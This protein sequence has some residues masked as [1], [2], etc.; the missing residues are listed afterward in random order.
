LFRCKS[1]ENMDIATIQPRRR[2]VRSHSDMSVISAS[3]NRRHHRQ[4]R[5]L[6]QPMSASSNLSKSDQ[7][8]LGSTSALF[9]DLLPNF[10]DLPSC[11]SLDGS[12]S[13]T[14]EDQLIRDGFGECENYLP[15]Y[16]DLPSM[17]GNDGDNKRAENP[18]DDPAL[19]RI[20]PDIVG[21]ASYH[22]AAKLKH[23]SFE[24]N[25]FG[26]PFSQ[27]T[28]ETDFRLR[29]FVIAADEYR[30]HRDDAAY[31]EMTDDVV[32]RTQSMD[33]ITYVFVGHG[34]SSLEAVGDN[35]SGMVRFSSEPSSYLCKEAADTGRRFRE[36][37]TLTGS[38]SDNCLLSADTQCPTPTGRSLSCTGINKW[39]ADSDGGC[40][41]NRGSDIGNGRRQ[42][43]ISPCHSEFN[44]NKPDVQT[45]DKIRPLMNDALST[46]VGRSEIVIQS[47]SERSVEQPSLSVS[48]IRGSQVDAE[49]IT[50]QSRQL[51]QV[52]SRDTVQFTSD[53]DRSDNVHTSLMRDSEC[54][55]ILPVRSGHHVCS[56]IP[57]ISS[58]TATGHNVSSMHTM[59]ESQRTKENPNVG[60][61]R[62]PSQSTDCDSRHNLMT[63]MPKSHEVQHLLDDGTSASAHSIQTTDDQGRTVETQTYLEM[64]V[65]ETQTAN[66]LETCGTQTT[67]YSDPGSG[68]LV[69]ASTDVAF[70]VCS[71]TSN[72]KLHTPPADGLKS[73][74]LSPASPATVKS[75][76]VISAVSNTPVITTSSVDLQSPSCQVVSSVQSRFIVATP[77]VTTAAAD[78]G[79]GL[80]GSDTLSAHPHDRSLNRAT[81][82][83]S[84]PHHTQSRDR[85]SCEQNTQTSRGD[86]YR[87]S[88][89]L[90]AAGLQ[91]S[92]RELAECGMVDRTVHGGT[93]VS[94]GSDLGS[95]VHGVQTT[96]DGGR[97]SAVNTTGG[98]IQRSA[99]LSGP[100]GLGSHCSDLS[101]R[102]RTAHKPDSHRSVCRLSD[103]NSVH[104]L[105]DVLSP[106]LKSD[107]E[108]VRTCDSR[109]NRTQEVADDGRSKLKTD[110]ILEKYRMRRIAETDRVLRASDE[111]SASS[112]QYDDYAYHLQSA[113]RSQASSSY[114]HVND[115]GIVDGQHG[116]SPLAQTWLGFG[117]PGCDKS[118]TTEPSLRAP[119]GWDEELE[120][121]HRERQRIGDLLAREV[122][123]SRI[124][125]EL[126]EA[127]LNY[128]LGQTDSLLRRVDEPMVAPRH[129]VSGADYRAFCLARLEASQS[130][131]EAQIQ[132]LE[133]VRHRASVRAA[134]LAANLGPRDA[135]ADVGG[136]TGTPGRHYSTV[137]SDSSYLFP[138][139]LSPSE[140]EQLLLGIRREI[141]SA[142]SFQSLPPVCSSSG[143]RHPESVR[144]SWPNRGY[145]S[146]HSSSL[147]IGPDDLV[148]EDEP[149][150]YPS[151][152]TATPAAASLRHLG[153]RRRQRRHGT[154]TSSMNDE[155]NL[156]LTE[157]HEARQRARVEIGRAVDAIQQTSPTATSSRLAVRRYV[158][159]CIGHL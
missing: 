141:V 119:A 101:H 99:T 157:C 140:R 76:V 48:C 111:S 31:H 94:S 142:T 53:S 128:L 35:C 85:L 52:D 149:E 73:E 39:S 93:S 139:T 115:S 105:L 45:P 41:Y 11:L 145:S 37:G 77:S 135:A 13:E 109:W 5:R 8:L 113:L 116:L 23:Q 50:N 144:R 158:R 24:N 28:T 18:G 75:Q 153:D 58:A 102:D 114:S 117:H 20:R 112:A 25:S 133:R 6:G 16:R 70:T 55:V 155:I 29:P 136:E 159:T 118:T 106:A 49:A 146:V 54:R 91:L 67:Y 14:G 62:Q 10:K 134:R 150:W 78:I 80:Y 15:W 122:I 68:D 81:R 2:L 89:S 110:E 46:A 57:D 148:R 151:P 4:R 86:S 27:M 32:H 83:S 64:R 129:D 47:S 120:T 19:R 65:I 127:H 124:Q 69:D 82:S 84:S 96:V 131:I 21:E 60:V 121:L 9:E 1:M 74:F 88:L 132:Q 40:S 22:D 156:L 138:T 36:H 126:V 87:S 66:N 123:P 154:P 100:P 103:S 63:V 143:R 7:E 44:H 30:S 90:P 95:R 107:P 12:D 98:S 97:P 130:H 43:L 26:M 38:T 152:S 33:S 42:P 71:S 147:N 108:M 34:A 17:R 79:T 3:R 125:V 72:Q 104:S 51:R 92:S 137:S 56:D 59:D 61:F